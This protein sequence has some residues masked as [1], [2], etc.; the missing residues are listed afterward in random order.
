MVA[1][2]SKLPLVHDSRRH[3]EIVKNGVQIVEIDFAVVRGIADVT[4]VHIDEAEIMSSIQRVCNVV[5]NRRKDNP[6][7]LPVRVP[8]YEAPCSSR[9]RQLP[10][11]V[12]DVMARFAARQRHIAGDS[13]KIVGSGRR[14]Q[15]KRNVVLADRAQAAD[16]RVPSQ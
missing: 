1:A 2:P 9:A 12:C 14:S 13:Q 16:G 8:L 11:V 7:S 4:A 6:L 10:V 15:V 3:T 5:D